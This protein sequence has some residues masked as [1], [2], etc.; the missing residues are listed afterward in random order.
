M[1]TV[2]KKRTIYDSVIESPIQY[3]GCFDASIPRL[4]P[5]SDI[6][7]FL[8]CHESLKQLPKDNY[9]TQLGPQSY[10]GVRF[11][12]FCCRDSIL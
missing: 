3:K 6:S 5:V 12:F 10:D 9:V 2:E 11:S 7:F 1:D 8:S 4:Q